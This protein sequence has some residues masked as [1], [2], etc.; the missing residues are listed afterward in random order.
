MSLSAPPEGP[1]DLAPAR[2]SL[3]LTCVVLSWFVWVSFQ[4]SQLAR[5]KSRLNQL[6]AGQELALQESAKVRAQM[7]GLA[8][9]TAKVAAQGHAGAQAIM[10]ELQRRGIRIDVPKT[11]PPGK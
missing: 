11:T 7:E 5:D 9:D 1:G 6:K 3:A 10:A 8:A 2:A 4:T